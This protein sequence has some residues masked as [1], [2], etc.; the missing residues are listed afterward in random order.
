MYE[1][2]EEEQGR[3]GLPIDTGRIRVSIER[4]WR[5]IP[6]SVLLAAILGVGAALLIK[7]VYKS[8]TVM[9]WEPVDRG[10]R[11]EREISTQAGVLK[12]PG[13]IEEVRKQLDLPGPTSRLADGIDVWFDRRSSLVTVEASGRT[14]EE[15]A[16]VADTL[17]SVFLQHQRTLEQT[18]ASE[19]VAALQ[20]DLTSARSAASAAQTDYDAFRGSH[21]VVDP[22]AEA[23]NALE[24]VNR[25]KF[26]RAT[27]AAEATALEAQVAQLSDVVK[28]QP[29]TRV[30]SASSSDSA[31]QP[32][33]QAR[34]ELSAAQERLSPKH[35]KVL[36]LQ[37]QIRALQ[38]QAA[39]GTT[40][41][42]STVTAPDPEF[43]SMRAMLSTARA[44][45]AAAAERGKSYEQ[46][47]AAAEETLA[48]LSSIEAKARVHVAEIE[49][50]NKRVDDINSQMTRSR[51]AVRA[52][53]PEFRVLTPAVVP[54]FPE[55]SKRRLVLAGFI[56]LGLFG[57]LFYLVVRP[58]R[59]G[60]IH[61]AREAAFWANLPVVAS[62]SWP[63]REEI[64]Y[65]FLDELSDDA[66][67][68]AG[69]TLIFGPGDRETRLA[70]DLAQG[71]TPLPTTGAAA[72]SASIA[73]ATLEPGA[74]SA[75]AIETDAPPTERHR[76]PRAE[77]T[78]LVVRNRGA[79]TFFAWR[80]AQQGPALRRA[81][82]IADRVVIVVASGQASISLM[83]GLRSRLG[84]ERGMALILVDVSEDLLD[85]PDRVGTGD[86]FWHVGQAFA[87]K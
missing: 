22:I 61:T 74:M 66:L 19:I 72:P 17:V 63:R 1:D 67:R 64:F 43:D 78:A 4:G 51:E 5:L 81:A 80:G 39:A 12:L 24:T 29:K 6:I 83:T 8:E 34:A 9:I 2:E 54:E 58:L 57:S 18:R 36:A 32:L 7:H 25:L 65:P 56:F 28:R 87:P 44:E 23:G 48:R 45:K 71:L 46:T 35:P 21:G 47:L 50:A 38:E 52:P 62:T 16:R 10:S 37:A 49:R 33:A 86:D 75:P 76:E 27:A 26:Q 42:K 82:R 60:C 84:R 13:L 73:T 15:A 11:A 79:P 68:T 69:T 30:Q 14:A 3:P 85:L 70:I 31:A 59:D 55:K 20:Q 77:S 41:V 40:V 53:T